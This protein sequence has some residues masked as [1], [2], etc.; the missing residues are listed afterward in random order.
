MTDRQFSYARL[1]MIFILAMLSLCG[2]SKDKGNRRKSFEYTQEYAF[3]GVRSIVVKSESSKFYSHRVTG[4]IDVKLVQ[5]KDERVVFSIVRASDVDVFK[6][7]KIGNTLK[8]NAGDK[9]LDT[10][11]HPGRPEAVVTVYT[12]DINRIEMGGANALTAT[13]YFTGRSMNLN[14]YGA[15][16]VMGLSGRWNDLNI[17]LSGASD[18]NMVKVESSNVNLVCEDASDF[19]ISGK[20]KVFKITASGSTDVEAENFPV[21]DVDAKLKGAADVTVN[22]SG[23]VKYTAT[24]SA[25]F[26]WVGAPQSIRN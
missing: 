12:K 6:I 19:V 17:K 18:L 25:D 15:S 1:A 7:E 26:D 24:G 5:S 23:T 9:N 16:E 13:G 4:Q 8:I 10:T 2:F 20:G 3:S 11:G 21:K 14:L 22:A